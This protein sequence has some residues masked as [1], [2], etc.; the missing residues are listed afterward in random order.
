MEVS[1]DEDSDSDGVDQD[2]HQLKSKTK[3]IKWQMKDF[4]V[5]DLDGDDDDDDD[6]NELENSFNDG[7]KFTT[8]L[9]LQ[10]EFLYLRDVLNYLSGSNP[11]YYNHLMKLISDNDQQELS[12]YI[13]NAE[14]RFAEKIKN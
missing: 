8:N 6:Y 13:T 5:D 3:N 10:D 9:D 7:A 1:G 14:L 12:G 2:E 11:E 4:I